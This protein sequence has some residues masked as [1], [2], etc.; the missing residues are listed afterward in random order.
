MVNVKPPYLVD[1]EI[2]SVNK[3][4]LEYMRYSQK[5]PHQLQHSMQQ[6]VQERHL[7]IMCS[8]AVLC[9]F[10]RRKGIIYFAETR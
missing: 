2:E 8:K 3:F 1:L 7:D 5:F 4:I 9:K 6:F 10:M